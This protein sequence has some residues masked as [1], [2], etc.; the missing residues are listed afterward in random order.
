MTNMA[1]YIVYMHTNRINKKKYVGVTS[2]PPHVRFKKGGYGYINNREMWS[3]IQKY[4]WDNFEHTIVAVDLSPDA[5]YKMEAAL[6]YEHKSNNPKYGYNVY[7]GGY[8]VPSGANNVMSKEIKCTYDGQVQVYGS[9]REASRK[10]G[11][12]VGRINRSRKTGAPVDCMV[13][14][15]VK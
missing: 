15:D 7:P 5:A 14:S 3:D 8:E 4:G 9:I 1:C 2:C 10:T 11:I 6:I 12:S 13:F